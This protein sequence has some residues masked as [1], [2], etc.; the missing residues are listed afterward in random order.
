MTSYMYNQV[1][2]YWVT[3][4]ILQIV[5]CAS[6]AWKLHCSFH[7]LPNSSST[8]IGKL[9]EKFLTDLGL[10]VQSVSLEALPTPEPGFILSTTMQMWALQSKHNMKMFSTLILS[11]WSSISA[12]KSGEAPLSCLDKGA[13]KMMII[14]IIIKAPNNEFSIKKPATDHIG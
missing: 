3:I 5:P 13:I 2:L 9:R 11:L 6:N 12:F 14:I 8:N 7:I 10:A 1:K 4:S